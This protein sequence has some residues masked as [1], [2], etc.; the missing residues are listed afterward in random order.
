M[1]MF[2]NR[3]GQRLIKKVRKIITKTVKLTNNKLLLKPKLDEENIAGIIKK[4]EK[5]FI[6]TPVK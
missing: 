1:K 3:I 6:I 5:G 2:F 4:I